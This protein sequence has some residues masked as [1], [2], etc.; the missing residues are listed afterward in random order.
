M[1]FADDFDVLIE[2]IDF[3]ITIGDATDQHF[4]TAVNEVRF[5][6]CG[7]TKL[8]TFDRRQEIKLSERLISLEYF[9]V[10]LFGQP[11]IFHAFYIRSS[12][13]IEYTEKKTH[14]GNAENFYLNSKNI[15]F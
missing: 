8:K 11:I 6:I 4:S 7:P 9:K 12:W 14:A 10:F 5:F 3:E 2:I 13:K 1:V 15:Q